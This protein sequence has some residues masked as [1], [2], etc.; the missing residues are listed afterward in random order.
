MSDTELLDRWQKIADAKNPEAP[1]LRMVLLES[2]LAAEEPS[3]TP[4]SDGER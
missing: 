3:T 1:T 4:P 2:I